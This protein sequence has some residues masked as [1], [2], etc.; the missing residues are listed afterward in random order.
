M[1]AAS[2]GDE[3]GKSLV[4]R[5]LKVHQHYTTAVAIMSITKREYSL[6][7]TLWRVS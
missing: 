2:S 6:R 4:S 5:N 3:M 1:A 7:I